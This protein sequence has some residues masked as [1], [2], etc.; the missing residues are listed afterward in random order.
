M[1]KLSQEKLIPIGLTVFLLLVGFYYSG[2]NFLAHFS[3]G[4]PSNS[5]GGGV[6]YMA[7]G[8]HH[9][10]FYRYSL[11]FDNLIRGRFP[12]YTGYQFSEQSFTEGLVFFP[13]S[14]LAGLIS[15]IFGPIVAFNL[16]MVISYPAVGLAGY[17]MVKSITNDRS[18][19]LVGGIFLALLPFRTSFLYG[20]MV[21]GVDAIL[22]PLLIGC[23]EHI[24]K[25]LSKSYL[26][27]AGIILFF[28][29]TSNF[30]MFYWAML[31]LAPYYLFVLICTLKKFH[32]GHFWRSYLYIL[33]GLILTVLYGLFIIEMMNT[34]VLD[35]GQSF[36]ETLFYTPTFD[37]LFSRFSGNEK[38]VYLGFTAPFV[39]L[40]VAAHLFFVGR[41]FK[42]SFYLGGLFFLFCT[43]FFFIFGPRF[44]EVS[45]LSLFRWMFDNVP[46]FNGTRTTGRIM[47]VV[48]VIYTLLLASFVVFLKKIFVKRFAHGVFWRGGIA[49][50]SLLIV[51]DF[52]Y[53]NPNISLFMAE[54]A[55][56][57]QI[58]EKQ[59]KVLT[60]PFQFNS[61]HYKNS[62]FLP[63]ALKYDMRL[64]TGHSSFYPRAVD[65]DVSYLYS[66]NDGIISFEQVSWL[67][68][69]GYEY[70]VVHNTKFEPRVDSLV[71][72]AFDSSSM[73]T[74]VTEDSGVIVYKISELSDSENVVAMDFEKLNQIFVAGVQS[75]RI[76]ISDVQYAMGWYDR[77]EYPNER[78]FRWMS[79]LNAWLA[80]P[81]TLEQERLLAFKYKCPSLELLQ[82]ASS[83]NLPKILSEKKLDDDWRE[84]LFKLPSNQAAFL[85]RLRTAHL[86]SVNT[87]IRSFGCQV[88]DVEFK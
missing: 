62:T 26:L 33:P 1:I 44:D 56:Y 65:K 55:A 64:L 3:D 24:K 15:F 59:R 74:R 72:A 42:R 36:E 39:L 45:K 78:P 9:E 48:A 25:S 52:G 31:L 76:V 27:A 38:N 77:E 29:I 57:K 16:I 79:G 5:V 30:Q 35:K 12:Y 50:L 20:Q 54:N 58:A 2:W 68:N 84:V 53:L 75:G 70:I 7:P 46:G 21:Y 6:S 43:G 60:I 87:D 19:A 14:A 40:W 73:I 82:F 83:S 28:M 81:P 4:I 69:R 37:Q 22:L 17:F 8:D 10:Q 47:S 67:K 18:A 63:I 85:L 32:V 11:F 49:L 13:F 51:L 23:C 66:I 34:G 88:G 71:V 61:A 41:H 80:I 86:F